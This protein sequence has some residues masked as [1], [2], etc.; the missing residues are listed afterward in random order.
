LGGGQTVDVPKYGL[1]FLLLRARSKS[2]IRIIKTR[3]D[4][5][6]VPSH[7]INP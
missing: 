1:S 3:G 4:P 6:A 7:G 5:V 2:P